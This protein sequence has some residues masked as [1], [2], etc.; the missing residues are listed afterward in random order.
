MPNNHISHAPLFTE[1][2]NHVELRKKKRFQRTHK[3][4]MSTPPS[5]QTGLKRKNASI[6]RQSYK[7]LRSSND[8]LIPQPPQKS[9]SFFSSRFGLYLRR[10]LNT[11]H[12][13]LNSYEINPRFSYL[14]E[15]TLVMHSCEFASW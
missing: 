14:E 11:I 4:P 1:R 5:D 6:T 15:M 3:I 9:N 10:A 12:K 8:R 7:R 2:G 13:K